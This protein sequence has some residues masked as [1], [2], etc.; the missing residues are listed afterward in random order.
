MNYSFYKTIISLLFFA[1]WRLLV[2][3]SPVVAQNITVK[4]TTK[5]L[6]TYPFSDPDPVP[7]TGRIYPYFRF[8]G[9]T[10]IPAMKDWKFVELENQYIKVA[11]TPEIGGKIWGAY[12]KS[13]HFPFVYFNN[14]V[15]FRDIAMRGAWTS[16]GIELNFGD[17]GHDPTVSTPVDYTTRTNADGSV[18]CFL[19]AWDWAS[20]TRWT[21]EVNL[22][23][24]KALFSTKSRWFN[25]SPLDQ[26]YYHWM[27]AGFRAGGNLEFIFPGTHQIGHGGE[28]GTWPTDAQGRKVNFYENNNFGTYKS[29][30]VLG[31]ATDFFGGYWHK[32]QA[33]FVHYAPYHEK[34]GKK[35]WIWGLSPQGM[36]WEKLLTDTDG[37]YVELQS[38][39][40]FNQASD[41][42]NTP[43]KHLAFQPYTSDSWTENWYPVKQTGG[44]TAANQMGALQLKETPTHLVWNY[45]PVEGGEKSFIVK[46]ADKIVFEKTLKLSP[47]V[48]FVDSVAFPRTG[49]IAVMIGG[50][51]LF[52]EKE[53]TNES[54]INRPLS[55]PQD[56]DWSSEYGLFLKAKELANQ[57]KYTEAEEGF[58]QCLQKNPY[59]VPALGEM[60][61]L[62]YRKG[63]YKQTLE[64]TDKALSVY[65]YDPLAN[66]MRGL[67]AR[68]LNLIATAKDGFSVAVLSPQFRAGALTELAKIAIEENDLV[69]AERLVVQALEHHPTNDHAKH[70]QIIILR[71]TNR[72]AE[73]LKQIKVVL[74]ENPLDHFARFEEDLLLKT[75]EL[76][77]YITNELPHEDYLEMAHWYAEAGLYNEATKL[78]EKG[79][80]HVL[81]KLWAIDM[82]Q[83]SQL[84]A[85][86]VSS[87]RTEDI[88][89]LL[90]TNPTG[91]FPSRVEDIAMLQ[92]FERNYNANKTATLWQLSYYQGLVFWQLGRL[93]EAKAV[94]AACESRPDVALFYLAKA[95]LFKEQKEMVREALER[96]YALEPQNWRTAK[97]L[98][99]FYAVNSDVEKALS[100]NE[101]RLMNSQKQTTKHHSQKL[102]MVEHLPFHEKY[103]L[104]QQRAQLL[105]KLGRYKE[106]IDFMQTLQLL[107]NEGASAAHTLYREANIQQSLL[108]IKTNQW[109]EAI[110][111]LNQA[112]TWPE[113]L[114]SGAPYN[115]D[116]RLTKYMKTVLESKMAKKIAPQTG[117]PEVNKKDTELLEAFLKM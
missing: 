46:A 12:E 61:Q 50:V 98:A 27:N 13:T 45:C 99:E 10:D 106:C 70:L 83:K 95:E 55:A 38:G 86:N 63:L 93:D 116:N 33:G 44:I 9:Y 25:A 81:V 68:K 71:K 100:V 51:P 102:G 58:K 80:N 62:N 1:T 94:F 18:S 57:R 29:Y 105:A 3:D 117:K 65:T 22:P 109:K 15:K 75:N 97:A 110:G 114:G 26:T 77:K 74:N 47:L 84:K 96:A 6:K 8:D 24:D 64:L 101:S 30:H 31:K 43:F 82:V 21:V 108:L 103:I 111:Y 67:S 40:L 60:A 20:H 35:I 87:Y 42:L 92:R 5:N 39:R 48:N 32:D 115:P 54:A 19:G 104:G 73:A 56:F 72:E 34:L 17:I 85:S 36:I 2:T 28:V 4:E 76:G 78:L 52:E 49:K 90:Q 53:L 88:E 16:G 79:P 107:P 112:E 113:N 91:I 59:H 37:Q 7:K 11:I 14:V 41:N 66:Y 89:K 23:K 69:K